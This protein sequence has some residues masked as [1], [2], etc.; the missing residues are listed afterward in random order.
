MHTSAFEG[1]KDSVSVYTRVWRRQVTA[2]APLA[3][4]C[5]TARALA[6][7]CASSSASKSLPEL[8]SSSSSPMPSPG[9]GIA[10]LAPACTNRAGC[11][12]QQHRTVCLAGGLPQ[13][14]QVLLRQ[15]GCLRYLVRGAPRQPAQRR[16]HP[17]P[18]ADGQ[19]Q[20]QWKRGSGVRRFRAGPYAARSRTLTQRYN[21][22]PRK[23]ADPL[24]FL[25]ARLLSGRVPT[26]NAHHT[27]SVFSCSALGSRGKCRHSGQR[28][29]PES[30]RGQSWRDERQ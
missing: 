20:A 12:G 30:T 18:A 25:Q 21:L 19:A 11:R 16:N 4:A 7:A 29:G 24:G 9:T 5:A 13:R 27:P 1:S 8:S 15:L 10:D 17:E 2:G 22:L 6:T 14:K 26:W 28:L 3:S 23:T